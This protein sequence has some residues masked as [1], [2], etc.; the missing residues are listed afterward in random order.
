MLQEGLS[1]TGG[2]ESNSYR[3]CPRA[4]FPTD[5][6]QAQYRHKVFVDRLVGNRR[7][8]PERSARSASS[9][10]AATRYVAR[11]GASRLIQ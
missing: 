3:P 1:S 8:K 11:G 4:A 9:S 2:N 6:T 7:S 10:S 5:A